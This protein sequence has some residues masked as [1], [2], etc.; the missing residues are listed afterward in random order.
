MKKERP[1]YSIQ[2]PDPDTGNDDNLL[3]GVVVYVVVVVILTI[4][5]IL[6]IKG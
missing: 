4:F 3:F 5:K 6:M 2:E 1:E